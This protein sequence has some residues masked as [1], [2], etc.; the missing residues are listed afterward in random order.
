[1]SSSA[2]TQQSQDGDLVS[3]Y[4]AATKPARLTPRLRISERSFGGA[5]MRQAVRFSLSVAQGLRSRK[6]AV[7]LLFLTLSV[8]VAIFH[9]IAFGDYNPNYLNQAQ[10][11]LAGKLLP[12]DNFAPVGYSLLL[13]WSIKLDGL[14]GIII[15]QSIIYVATVM[16]AWWI[17]FGRSKRRLPNNSLLW[18][19][20]MLIA[21]ALHPYMLIDTH[22]IDDNAF[23]V[24]FILI[25]ASWMQNKFNFQNQGAALLLG[26][27][28]GFF[29]VFR[30]NAPIFAVFLVP[31]LLTHDSQITRERALIYLLSVAVAAIAVYCSIVF[32][33]TG[34]PFFWPATGP[35]NLFAG[36]NFYSFNSLID[37]FNAEESIPL[38][39]D[40]LGFGKDVDVH[41]FPP[42]VYSV[43]AYQFI[44][45]HVLGF[46]ALCFTKL[47]VL[48]AP[49]ITRYGNALY[50][51][52][53]LALCLPVL[54]WS[55]R[56]VIAWR[57]GMRA[58]CFRRAMFVTLFILPFLVTNSDPHYRV[59]LD[60]WMLIDAGLLSQIVAERGH[61]LNSANSVSA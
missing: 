57:E 40:K 8:S 46:I 35:Y 11:L 3:C 55:S 5:M 30:P 58:D 10:M 42:H 45:H 2:R 33:A 61:T 21:V 37:R 14:A 1:M 6:W 22:R 4:M 36:N 44:I 28:L 20:A 29:T 32:A 17:L 27:A 18:S 47:L 52:A 43:Q 31:T 16:I 26:A 23:N 19:L 9:L 53:Q 50:L 56:L 34:T 12:R 49:R 59:P 25:L 48:F 13:A 7:V 15:L 41:T 24:L 39:L 38:A 54:I 51:S 60:I